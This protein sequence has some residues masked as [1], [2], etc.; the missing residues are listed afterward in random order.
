MLHNSSLQLSVDSKRDSLQL[1]VYSQ[2]T[3]YKRQLTVASLQ[4][5]KQQKINKNYYKLCIINEQE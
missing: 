2:K 3:K 5:N 1:A 4:Q